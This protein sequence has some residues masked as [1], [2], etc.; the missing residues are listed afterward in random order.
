MGSKHV[1][2]L[3]AGLIFAALSPMTAAAKG[4][5]AELHDACEA[6]GF[7]NAGGLGKSAK[8]I[9]DCMNPLM[10][11]V[12]PP[13]NGKIALPKV[14]KAALDAC[15]AVKSTSPKKNASA[16]VQDG[17]P[18]GNTPTEVKALPANVS[19]GPN[20]VMVLVDD[21]SMNLMPDDLGDLAKSMP[22]LAQMRREG[23]TFDNYFVTDS[24]CCPSRTSIMTGL[25]PHNSGV[26]TNTMPD[27]GL[28]AFMAHKNDAKT[29][30][31]ALNNAF[32]ATAL[33]GKYLNGYEAD[34]D[35]VPQGWSEW[36]VA[37]NAYA[38]FNYTINHNGQLI[39]PDLHMTDQL[40]LLGQEFI[41][42]ASDGPFFLELSTFSPHAPYTPPARYA[43]SFMDLTYPRT[44]AFAARPDPSQPKWM[45]DIPVLDKNFQRKIDD[46]YRLRV[47]SVKGVDDLIGDIRKTLD[48]LGLSKDTYVIFTSDNGYHLG[49]FSLRAG[50]MTPFDTDIHVPLVV[51]GPGVPAGKRVADLTMNIDLYPT[52][53]DLAG[54]PASA[55]VDGKSLVPLLKGQAGPG[56]QIAVVEHKRAPQGADD[57]DASS[58]KA[59]DPPTYVALRM[60]DTMYVEYLDGSG[61]VGF[62]DM[63]K[64]P[65][66]MV[67]I[68]S[69]LSPERLKAL[70]EAAVANH[71]CVGAAECGAAQ[72]MRP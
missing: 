51:L 62:Y 64:D 58:P 57:P 33:M 13:G 2:A 71:T 61:E 23:V 52:F 6:A 9:R 53:I 4:G 43:D 11:G 70:H 27:G 21:F 39:S 46:I 5:C 17:K 45:Q 10:T 30:A 24:L 31:V 7:S 72:A 59:G 38:N 29:Y 50:K 67:N 56:R 3:V 16:P 68:A 19:P 41:T 8:I 34:R 55:T 42:M 35:G 26:I 37:G 1:L 60:Q 54:L 28:G 44:P 40:S 36:A 49:E 65:D 48:D 20:I 15:K 69:T 63:T 22:N 18:V 14:S 66:Q 47:Q 32:Y 12:E 25:L